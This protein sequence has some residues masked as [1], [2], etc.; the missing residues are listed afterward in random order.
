MV[1]PQVTDEMLERARATIKEAQD[2]AIE[3]HSRGAFVVWQEIFE[4]LEHQVRSYRYRMRS[5]QS[6]GM[7]DDLE[8][9]RRQ[10]AQIGQLAEFG[11]ASVETWQD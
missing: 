5:F 3:K 2:A 10:L 8:E 1:R 7:D 4:Q 6:S 11:L 9:A